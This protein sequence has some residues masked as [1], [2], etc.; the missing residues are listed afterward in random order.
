MRRI[1]LTVI[2]VICFMNSF[3]VLLL[4]ESFSY[5]PGDLNGQNGGTGFVNSWSTGIGSSVSIIG[6]EFNHPVRLPANPISPPGSVS[7]NVQ[8][9]FSGNRN[10]NN[11]ILNALNSTDDIWMSFL[12]DRENL[13]DNSDSAVSFQFGLGVSDAIAFTFEGSNNIRITAGNQ[14]QIVAVPSSHSMILARVTGSASGQWDL[15]LFAPTTPGDMTVYGTINNFGFNN[16]SNNKLSISLNPDL[17]SSILYTLD[18][19]KVGTKLTDVAL[20]PEPA[21]SLCVLLGAVSFFR[22]IK[23]KND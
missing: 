13:G 4:N 17:L 15:T 19:I 8:I 12:H 1:F 23:K 14:F 21:T 20:V 3:A 16:T 10:Y 2:L 22:K 9:S 18:E 5:T 7:S 11:D 6:S